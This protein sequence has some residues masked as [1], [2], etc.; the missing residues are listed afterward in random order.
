VS[1]RSSR[2]PSV[3]PPKRSTPPVGWSSAP[4][5]WSSVVLPDPLGPVMATCS[6]SAIS[7]LTPLTATTDPN[8]RCTLSSA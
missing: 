5:S 2:P 1:S 3:S 7:K 4:S 8:E 6:P